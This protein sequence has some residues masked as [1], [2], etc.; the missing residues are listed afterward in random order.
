M[1]RTLLIIIACVMPL[2]VGAQ[3][4]LDTAWVRQYTIPGWRAVQAG[5]RQTSDNGYIIA[6][7]RDSYDEEYGMAA[8]KL[9]S[10]GNQVWFN[11]FG[12]SGGYITTWAV[13]PTADG[14]CTLVG[15]KWMLSLADRL[16]LVRVDV[17]GDSLWRREIPFSYTGDSFD[18]HAFELGNGNLGVIYS[19]IDI[20]SEVASTILY[21]FNDTGNN[22]G[23]HGLNGYI[24]CIYPLDGGGCLYGGTNTQFHHEY[25]SESAIAGRISPEGELVQFWD[26][27]N[28]VVWSSE[29][30]YAV[31]PT[32]DQ[33]LVFCRLG[34]RLERLTADWTSIEWSRFLPSDPTEYWIG[35]YSDGGYLV[36]SPESQGES[37]LLRRTDPWGFVSWTHAYPVGGFSH[38]L[39]GVKDDRGCTLLGTSTNTIKVVRLEEIADMRTVQV[40]YPNGGEV[41]DVWLSQPF[42][43]WSW[44]ALDAVRIE[45]NRNYPTG[46]WE[47]MRDSTENDGLDSVYISPLFSDSCRIRVQVLGDTLVDES[48]GCFAIQYQPRIVVS[49]RGWL[50]VERMNSIQWVGREPTGPAVRIELN[51]HYPSEQWEILADSTANDGEEECWI[52]FPMSDSCRLR[53]SSVS[54]TFQ[55]LSQECFI[56]YYGRVTLV[57]PNSGSVWQTLTYGDIRWESRGISR[58]ALDLNRDYPNGEWELIANNLIASDQTY[59]YLVRE[60]SSDHCRFRVRALDDTVKDVMDGDFSIELIP[61]IVVTYPNRFRS[62]YQGDTARVQWLSSDIHLP[63]RIRIEWHDGTHEIL[64]PRTEDDGSEDFVLATTRVSAFANLIVETLDRRVFGRST[65]IYVSN[66]LPLAIANSDGRCQGWDAGKIEAGES[67]VDTFRYANIRNDQLEINRPLWVQHDSHRQCFHFNTDCP[68]FFFVDHYELS[69]CAF[70]LVYAPLV[71]DVH[72]D[73]LLIPYR[74]G[75]FSDQYDTLRFPLVGRA[76]ATPAAPEVTI[77]VIGNDVELRWQPV[78]TNRHSVPVHVTGYLVFRSEYPN[79]MFHYTANVFNPY[80]R[81]TG[82]VSSDSV[83]FYHVIAYDGTEDRLDELTP[84][85]TEE[86]VRARLRE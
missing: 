21:I 2:W 30:F 4:M 67:I 17:N 12:D 11:T 45:L 59:R 38:L 1:W 83:M 82:V 81:D 47:V 34:R 56:G 53:I 78:T 79:G 64:V 71:V 15:W 48:D 75:Y 7:G 49:T 84:G 24:Q 6:M 18:I 51:R 3:P 5:F 57:A 73:T 37:L 63:L 31:A 80:Y 39:G 66:P 36:F 40:T 54:D 20:W 35:Q 28:Y 46:E 32:A 8:L 23:T 52:T 77:H 69:S 61:N 60:P 43:W 14:G 25:S 50:W 76:V 29:G 26:S 27:G 9:D 13:V 72:T 16:L 33:G 10:L 58:I 68:D 41:W 44:N 42:R 86:E 85:M 19:F 70:T 74:A 65:T 62:W 22:V 55:A